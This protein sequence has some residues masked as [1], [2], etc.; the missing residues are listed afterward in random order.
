M[1]GEGGIDNSIGHNVLPVAVA[2][3]DDFLARATSGQT[4][5][6]GAI[7]IRIRGWNGAAN[8]PTVEAVF[9]QTVF[10]SAEELTGPIGEVDVSDGFLRIDGVPHPIPEWD[11]GDW[12][13]V[14]EAAF[15]DGSLSRPRLVD[16][17]AFVADDV[18]VMRL[19]DRFPFYLGGDE[20]GVNFALTDVEFT[21]R[22]SAD[23]ERVEEAVLA[24]RWGIL[25]LLAGLAPT[26]I[27][28]D[29]PDYDAF[30]RLLTLSA[31]VRSIP[32]SGGPGALC[33][34]V[35]LGLAFD[36]GA[37]VNMGGLHPSLP[38]PDPCSA[39]MDAGIDASPLDAGA[40]TKA[41]MDGG[42]TG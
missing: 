42:S 24:G 29:S 36:D 9:M 40:D 39:T 3:R 31:D 21:V 1:D 37:R 14:Q 6:L 13:Y 32:N 20:S 33:D 41:P 7:M 23:H 30:T 2:V 16:D 12:F 4:Q 11:G 34:A 19:P 8:D 25:D 28:P 27:C 35:S 38:L 10:G 26:G 5:G 17:Q 22:F 18:L 15:L